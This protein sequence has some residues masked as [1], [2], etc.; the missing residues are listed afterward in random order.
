M[1]KPLLAGNWKMNHTR[2]TALAFAKA[3]REGLGGAGARA[4]VALFPPFPYLA[5]L[6]E[7][8][9]GSGVAVG[10]QD[11]H[12]EDPGAFT[13]AVSASMVLDCGGTMTLVGHSE[14]RQLFGETDAAVNR[15][16]KKALASS[17]VPVLCVGE[18]LPER[19]AGRTE[20]VVRTQLEGGL[21]G[22]DDAGPLAIAYEPVWAIGT[23]KTAT[24]AQAQEVH[25][26]IRAWLATRYPK[27]GD[28]VRILYGGSVKPNNI[29]EIRKGRD[30]DGALVGGA[31]LEAPSF[32]GIVKNALA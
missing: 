18:T 23:G 27:A 13:G 7:A 5:P 21:A 20:A 16:V 22:I 30:I 32:L 2:A 19:E 3:L 24:P 11:I 12:W 9:K 17:L 31:S 6:A 25:A 28:G 15:K 26:L 4:D 29:A 14:R 1:R 10:A 8:L